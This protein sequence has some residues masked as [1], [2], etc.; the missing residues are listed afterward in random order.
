M[1]SSKEALLIAGGAGVL[2]CDVVMLLDGFLVVLQDVV[3][4]FSLDDHVFQNDLMLLHQF[5]L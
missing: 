4:M 2:V 1:R 3:A 5:V